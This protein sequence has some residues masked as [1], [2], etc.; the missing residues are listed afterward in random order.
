MSFIN[1]K[2]QSYNQ[3]LGCELETA[4]T[5]LANSMASHLCK[6]I[7]HNCEPHYSLFFF[8]L[9]THF[10]IYQSMPFTKLCISV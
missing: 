3:P 5:P 7:Q 10:M 8:G 1:Q 6:R 2:T 4:D 9:S